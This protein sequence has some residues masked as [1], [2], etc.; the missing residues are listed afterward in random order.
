MRLTNEEI[1]EIVEETE[2]SPFIIPEEQNLLLN[3][4][5]HN[6]RFCSILLRDLEETDN[7]QS[8]VQGF[9][10]DILSSGIVLLT[11]FL[12]KKELLVG[13]QDVSFC[14]IY[15]IIIE[16]TMPD[17]LK[18]KFNDFMAKRLVGKSIPKNPRAVD[19]IK[20]VFSYSADYEQILNERNIVNKKTPKTKS[21]KKEKTKTKE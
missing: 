12:T 5:Y 21:K 4:A 15:R 14:E 1:E 2:S 10:T 6:E 9:I 7:T 11:V 8:L 19:S 18:T 17:E 20:N 16:E 13:K 3:E